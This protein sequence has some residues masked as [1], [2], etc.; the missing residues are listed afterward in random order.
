[1]RCRIVVDGL[2]SAVDHEVM[3]GLDKSTA[4]ED[5]KAKSKEG[6]KKKSESK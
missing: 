4:F 5:V 3:L 1:L 2:Y 6:K